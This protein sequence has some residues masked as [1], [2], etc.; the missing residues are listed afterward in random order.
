MLPSMTAG[1]VCREGRTKQKVGVEH[2][3][4]K[5]VARFKR[6]G[7]MPSLVMNGKSLVDGDQ[8]FDTSLIG[9]YQT[10]MNRVVHAKALFDQY[11]SVVRR[12]FHNDV[13]EFMGFMG[14]ISDPD[15][16]N[17]AERLG[18][19]VVRPPVASTPDKLDANKNRNAADDK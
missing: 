4:N 18:L 10:C 6:T 12:R 2:D 9:D 5:I 3:I 15:V 16:F 19:I 7:E 13:E 17:E 1:I 8:I 14:Q 11:P